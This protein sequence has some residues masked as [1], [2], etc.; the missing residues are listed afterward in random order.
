[1]AARLH[2]TGFGLRGGI[3]LAIGTLL[4]GVM[5]ITVNWQAHRRAALMSRLQGG[6]EDLGQVLGLFRNETP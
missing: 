2:M 5:L 4:A 6:V 3:L 1:M